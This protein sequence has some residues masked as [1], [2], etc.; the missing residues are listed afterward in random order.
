[1]KTLKL[2]GKLLV[3]VSLATVLAAC[4]GPK[5]PD[6]VALAFWEAMQA[7]DTAKAAMLTT[8]PKQQI[9]PLNEASQ[10]S[11]LK[12]GE[13]TL[14]GDAAAVA[15]TIIKKNEDGSEKPIDFQTYLVK[16]EKGWRVDWQQ[17]WNHLTRGG[18]NSLAET[19]EELARTFTQGL[20]QTM[21][22][23]SDMLPKITQQLQS[24]GETSVKEL[25]NN[26]EQMAPEIEQSITEL[27]STL[28]QT[29]KQGSE[30]LQKDLTKGV[31]ELQEQLPEIQKEMEQ[32][33]RE[34]SKTLAE[35]M[36]Q[37]IQDLNAK[38]KELQK[39]LDQTE[40]ETGERI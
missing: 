8:D 14:K 12:I 13:V 22:K 17:T 3:G 34:S 26:W 9:K 20:D 4:G 5:T 38:L 7:G 2:I 18:N 16:T 29:M 32:L 37:A 35:S 19:L 23:L 24:L 10:K 31:E 28:G 15:T 40:Q 6:E 30:K 21:G 11:E 1:M 27:S 25:Q 33:S 36:K 39:E